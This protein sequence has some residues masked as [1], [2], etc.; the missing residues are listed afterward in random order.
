M[1]TL[2]IVHTT[3]VT[4]DSLKALALELMPEVSV[5]NFVDDSILPQLKANGGDV[6]KVAQRLVQYAKFAEEVG[7]SV[8]LNAC[9]S[10][11]EV[12][13]LAQEAVSIPVVRIDEA[14]AEKAVKTG[15]KIVVAATLGTT[16]DPTMR[17]LES[18]A[19]SSGKNVTLDALLVAEAY[20]KLIQGDK[21]GHDR[22]LAARLEE[23]GKTADVVVLAQASMA[24]VL[25]ALP[26]SKQGKFLTSP[27]LGME[28]VKVV[29]EKGRAADAPSR[30]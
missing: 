19:R 25:T 28:R 16:L 17:L 10:V 29:L 23:A 24:Q 9:S 4:V 30:N 6:S 27:R 5:V 13:P 15:S 7:A 12:V 26:A 22:L 21:E 8:I 11:G 18:K 20:E 2:A 14:M 3:S 1:S